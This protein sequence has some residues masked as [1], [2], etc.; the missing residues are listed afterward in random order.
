MVGWRNDGMMGQIP[1]DLLRKGGVWQA[2][3]GML[4]K[5]EGRSGWHEKRRVGGGMGEKGRKFLTIPDQR[6]IFVSLSA[7]PVHGCFAM[8]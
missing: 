4:Y 6:A 8:R 3:V 5:R 1:P 2:Q 7:K